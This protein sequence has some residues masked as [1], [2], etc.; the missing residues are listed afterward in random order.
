MTSDLENA[1]TTVDS[2]KEGNQE[3]GACE[4]PA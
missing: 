4:Q 1:V 3:P 2:A